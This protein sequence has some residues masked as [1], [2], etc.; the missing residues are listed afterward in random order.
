MKNLKNHKNVKGFIVQLPFDYKKAVL[1]EGQR[2]VVSHGGSV[3]GSLVGTVALLDKDDNLLA[4]AEGDGSIL[5][6]LCVFA[7]N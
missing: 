7:G 3:S 1:D 5:K 2:L 4:V 6:P